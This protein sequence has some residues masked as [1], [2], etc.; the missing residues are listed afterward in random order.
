MPMAANR[1]AAAYRIALKGI[2]NDEQIF[3]SRGECHGCELGLVAHLGQEECDQRNG[4][5]AVA[6]YRRGVFLLDPV[7]NERPRRNGEERK[8]KDPAQQLGGDCGS[9]P[10]SK[11]AGERVIEKRSAKN[12]GDDRY[13]TSKARGQQ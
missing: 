3:E 6:T 2:F 11:H 10:V 7:R 4:E 5:N 12:A 13:R 8:A 9:N 1:T